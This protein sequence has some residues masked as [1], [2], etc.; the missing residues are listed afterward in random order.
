MPSSNSKSQAHRK[1]MLLI[2]ACW[3][4]YMS[5]YIGRNTFKASIAPIVSAGIMTNSQAGLIE[6]CYLTVYGAGHLINGILADRLNPYKM[7]IIGLFGSA[8]ANL[9]MALAPSYPIMLA[10]W[11]INGFLQAMLWSPILALFSRVILPELRDTACFRIFTSSPVG[12][13][14]AYLLVVLTS[15]VD[16]RFTFYIAALVLALIAVV[17]RLISRSAAP[18]LNTWKIGAQS[19]EGSAQRH[20]LLPLL[21]KTGVPVFIFA[22]ILHGMLKEGVLTWVPSIISDSYPIDVTFSVFLSMLLPISNLFGAWISKTVYQKLL[23]RNEALTSCFFM[24]ITL[25]PIIAVSRMAQLPLAI[26]VIC[27]AL[28]SMLMTSFNYMVS[29]MIPMRFAESG[30]AA[31]FSGIFNSSVYLG[32]AISTWASG[33]IADSYGWNTTVLVWLGIAAVGTIILLPIFPVWK[34]F[35]EKKPSN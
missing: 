33:R 15:D 27:L 12:T 25:L 4:V 19:T 22:T 35:I 11:A 3:L 14:V 10:V 8:T 6:T 20:A 21:L 9:I 32:S 29:T 24:L 23:H 7:I 34:R 16:Y 2:A 30:W 28:I 1:S 13:I 18:H 5:A 17:F 26:S 31:T